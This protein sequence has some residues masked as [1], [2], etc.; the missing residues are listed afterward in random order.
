MLVKSAAELRCPHL[1]TGIAERREDGRAPGTALTPRSVSRSE[2]RPDTGAGREQP[3]PPRGWWRLAHAH[4]DGAAALQ[5]STLGARGEHAGPETFSR[6]NQ[7]LAPPRPLM[8][9]TTRPP[10]HHV[11]PGAPHSARP[12]WLYHPHPRAHARGRLPQ[13]QAARLQGHSHP[14]AGRPRARLCQ[15]SRGTRQN[16]S[17][18]VRPPWVSNSKASE[19]A[20]VDPEHRRPP[21]APSRGVGVAGTCGAAT[22][23]DS[24]PVGSPRLGP[25]LG[26]GRASPPAAT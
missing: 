9:V 19:Q 21:R 11:A 17:A 26:S 4:G 3:C 22:W 7:H 8:H 13:R 10:G 5:G 24:P 15:Q 16:P 6:T 20:T 14:C 1:P 23:M 25:A 18:S 2:C 12:A